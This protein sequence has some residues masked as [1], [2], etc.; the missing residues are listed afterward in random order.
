M[1]KS[2]R[3]KANMTG[4]SIH[5]YIYRTPQGPLAIAANNDG[6][7]RLSFGTADCS[8]LAKPTPLTNRAATELLEFFAGK[9]T[10]FDLPLAPQGSEFQRAVWSACDAI[11]F[12]QTRTS[13]E[14]AE[15]L[16]NPRSYRSV[17]AA[18]RK[19]PLAVLVP[20][21][22]VVDA[23]GVPLASPLQAKRAEQLLA[24]ERT[25]A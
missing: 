14:I 3:K 5:Y 22:R 21:H 6:I 24:L 7:C 12:G 17:G 4:D 19:N 9:R 13:A 18:V 2:E 23:R 10:V 20:S 16:G 15:S 8:G 25:R 11:P 1:V